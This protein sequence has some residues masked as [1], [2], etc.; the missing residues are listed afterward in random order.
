[1]ADIVKKLDTDEINGFIDNNSDLNAQLQDINSLEAIL[2]NDN[3]DNINLST[4]NNITR[5]LNNNGGFAGN[6]NPVSNNTRNEYIYIRFSVNYPTSDEEVIDANEETKYMGICVTNAATAPTTYT[7]YKWVRI[8]GDTGAQGIAGPRGADG[9][10]YINI[11]N[12]LYITGTL[13]ANDWIRVEPEESRTLGQ[14]YYYQKF[15][16]TETNFSSTI[17]TSDTVQQLTNNETL[18]YLRTKLSQNISYMVDLVVSEDIR[19]GT[20]ET[21]NWNYLTRTYIE[22][23]E[24]NIYLCFECYNNCPT[25]NLKYQLKVV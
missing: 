19:I 14:P 7:S 1:M 13:Y 17:I 11:V 25:I 22:A 10:A 18:Q 4:V 23:E 16:I 15:N 2:K 5:Q 8:V 21:I 3:L 9:T 20:V 12:P 24:E 6:L